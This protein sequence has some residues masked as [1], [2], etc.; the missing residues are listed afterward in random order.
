MALV[1]GLG[2]SATA[3]VAQA[4]NTYVTP[5][6]G[7]LIIGDLELFTSGAIT[8]APP[9]VSCVYNYM[10]GQLVGKSC[11]TN[12]STTLLV[13]DAKTG[14]HVT[15]DKVTSITGRVVTDKET[16][17][18]P[19]PGP[20][21]D[22]KA[23][24]SFTNNLSADGSKESSGTLLGYDPSKATIKDGD[25]QSITVL[26]HHFSGSSEMSESNRSLAAS[27]IRYVEYTI[28]G[29]KV[30]RDYEKDVWLA[31][32]PYTT[33]AGTDDD[34]TKTPSGTDEAS[35]TLT[36]EQ[37]QSVAVYVELPT[38]TGKKITNLTVIVDGKTLV[39]GTDYTI[40]I[41]GDT[42][43]I[44]KYTA[45]I[46]GIGKYSGTVTGVFTVLPTKPTLS[47]VTAGK[48]QVTA[49]WKKVA[50]AQKITGYQ[51]RYRV[52]GT[53][54]W[55]SVKTVKASKL[56]YVA[57]KL[58]K[59]KKYQVQVRAYKKITSGTSKGTYYSVWSTTKTSAKV[60]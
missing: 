29:V 21:T 7:K 23:I 56:S 35:G 18:G 55:S 10:Y 26:F 27:Q 48:K 3:P 34:G 57:K 13:V 52:K 44:G 58:K 9:R 51:I 54:S 30:L 43:K 31:N 20:T 41:N 25:I 60:K 53:T 45:T 39:K 24:E 4:A 12:V 5:V 37:G 49:K 6:N 28:N 2:L 1:A 40:T 36:N 33:P 50:A 19:T 59:G 42:T 16:Y 15:P 32:D 46:T 11:R 17:G 47:K 8:A 14:S 38:W 22:W